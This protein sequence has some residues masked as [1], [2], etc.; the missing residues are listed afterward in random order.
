[1]SK[2][3]NKPGNT[4]FRLLKWILIS[5]SVLLFTGIVLIHSMD[6]SLSEEEI[7]S[8]FQGLPFSLE[9]HNFRY[10]E[11]NIFYTAI[12]DTN[13]PKVL[14]IHGSPGSWDNF[15]GFLK[16]EELLND[17]RMIAVDR[18]G[19]GKSG[20]G[21]PE[22]SLEKQAELIAEVLIR[23]NLFT[24]TLLVGHSY[25]GPVIA[26]M[27]IDYPSLVGGLVFVAPSID[28]ELEETKWY[29]IPVDYQILSWILPGAIYSSNEEILALK[30]E[31]QHML[32]LWEDIRVPV[33]IIQGDKDNLVPFQNAFFGDS[34]LVNAPVTV[35]L[36]N[37]M[38]HFVPWNRPDLIEK[39]MYS[40]LSK[41]DTVTVQE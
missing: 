39:S 40:V 7:R 17:F 20:A 27:A 38:G 29:Q 19:F 16:D 13:N 33:E 26:R 36:E 10:E 11:R 21:E 2:Q 6:F 22:R 8:S 31:L 4:V 12:G 18:P 37:E 5:F 32:P 3:A 1:M 25:G 9:Q 28:P 30:E 14:F 24:P 35:L 34:M 23:E 41:I 15:S